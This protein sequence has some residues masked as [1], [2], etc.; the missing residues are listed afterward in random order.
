MDLFEMSKN[1]RQI[2]KEE[3]IKNAISRVKLQ[4]S[5]LTYEQT[6]KIYSSYIYQ[7]LL[8]MHVSQ[9][10][11][12]T[13]DLGYDFEHQFIIVLSDEDKFIYLIDL[14]FSQFSI[15]SDKFIFLRENGFQKMNSETYQ[16]FLELLSFAFS[17][18]ITKK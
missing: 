17:K 9:Q 11:I 16:I 13:L 12:N 14:T 5:G 4:L 7:E 1:I 18:S 6:C 3:A 10:I 8:Q 15:V 2:N